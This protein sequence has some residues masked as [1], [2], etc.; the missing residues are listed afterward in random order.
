MLENCLF[1][2]L[3]APRSPN[4][5][6]GRVTGQSRKVTQPGRPAH[7]ECAAWLLCVFQQRGEAYPRPWGLP[8]LARVAKPC[9]NWSTQPSYPW[10]SSSNTHGLPKRRRGERVLRR[11]SLSIW[12]FAGIGSG[13]NSP[14]CKWELAQGINRP[15]SSRGPRSS[16]ACVG[17]PA[18]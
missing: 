9:M 17:V 15:V 8:R 18:G 10:L 7:W 12:T 16:S 2:I 6:S 4:P 13:L 1:K 5:Q 11:E 14:Y 3:V